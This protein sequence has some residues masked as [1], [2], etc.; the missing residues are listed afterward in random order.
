MELV[1]RTTSSALSAGASAGIGADI[2]AL[3][4]SERALHIDDLPAD[5]PTGKAIAHRPSKSEAKKSSSAPVPPV[6]PSLAHI[7]RQEPKPLRMRDGQVI[8]RRIGWAVRDGSITKTTVHRPLSKDGTAYRPAGD[9]GLTKR[10]R[11][12]GVASKS[13]GVAPVGHENHHAETSGRMADPYEHEKVFTAGYEAMSYLPTSVRRSLYA[14]VST[15]L[16]YDGKVVQYE[17]GTIEV[18]VIRAD[19][20]CAV[21]AAATLTRGGSTWDVSMMTFGNA[22][23]RTDLA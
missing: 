7:A 5:F 13:N 16:E 21:S 9:W 3:N 12:S 23:M 6:E 17:D 20:H 1:R 22:Q 2:A 10:T 18:V 11:W 4:F 15:P 14:R 8:Q 19:E